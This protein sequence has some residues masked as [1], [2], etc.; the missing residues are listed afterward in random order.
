MEVIEH[1][2]PERVPASSAN[3][4]RLRCGRG[5]VVVTTPNVEYN[6]RYAALA[7]GGLRHPDHRFEWTRA[8]F[9]AWAT[10]VG[11][12]VRLRR[13]AAGRSATVDAEVGPPTQL[14]VFTRT[15]AAA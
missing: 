13:R 15:E 9:A 10:A 5:T 12:D 8:E 7:D 2:D 14:A 6:V 1:I 11:D 4:V 3:A